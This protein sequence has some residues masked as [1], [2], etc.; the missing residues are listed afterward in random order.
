MSP[1]DPPPPTTQET[2]GVTLRLAGLGLGILTFFGAMALPPPEGLSPEG[3]RVAAV[4]MM[5]AIFWITEAIPLPATALI[6]LAAFP[7]LGIAP[8]G[9]AA[10]PYANPLIFLFLGGFVIALTM[11][12]WRLHERI[13]LVILRLS[14]DRMDRLIAGFM[15]ATAFLSMWVSNTAT[16]LMMLPIALSIVT[17]LNRRTTAEGAPGALCSGPGGGFA[18]ALLLSIAYGAS[19]GG[20]GTLVGTPPNA[21][22]A[23]FMVQNYGYSIG[24]AEWMGLALPLVVVLLFCVWWLATRVVFCLHGQRIE[25]AQALIAERARNQG[26]MS[27]GERRIAALFVLTAAAWVGRPW[28][29]ALF[30]GVALDDTVIAITAAILSF[31]IPVD[32]RRGIFL[33]NWETAKRLPFG[34]LILFGGGLTLASAIAASGLAEWIGAQLMAFGTLP[35]LLLI[36]IVTAVIVFLT[37][38]TSNT[39]TTAAFLPVMAAFAI[40]LGENPLLFAVPAAL[41]ASCAFMLPVATPPNAIVFGSD[42]LTIGQMARAGFLLNLAGI[43]IITLGAYALLQWMFSVAPGVLPDWAR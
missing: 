29:S 2:H 18:A 36:L 27:P 43:L 5:M 25:G 7:L 6:P 22:L 28:L 41:A 21:F 20:M 42:R 33:M 19:I 34:V 32:L 37:E 15:G 13:A 8:I 10:A 30:P 31:L 16:T 3:W 38:L 23:G 1:A 12:R 35:I 26:P 11:E 40:T 14:G 24:F 39:A 17:L 9:E 4:G